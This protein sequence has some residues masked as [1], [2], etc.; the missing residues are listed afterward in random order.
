MTDKRIKSMIEE[1]GS[2]TDCYYNLQIE[3]NGHV[4]DLIYGGRYGI[5]YICASGKKNIVKWLED[6]IAFY[7]GLDCYFSE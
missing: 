2:L 4:F 5:W 1:L 6:T 3:K 7:R